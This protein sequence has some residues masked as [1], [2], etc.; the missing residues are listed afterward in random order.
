MKVERIAVGSNF[1]PEWSRD[2]GA[3]R[4]GV[5]CQFISNADETG[6]FNDAYRREIMFRDPPT[7]MSHQSLS[8]STGTRNG[9]PSRTASTRTVSTCGRSAQSRS[10][11]HNIS[12]ASRAHRRGEMP[13]VRFPVSASRRFKRAEGRR[14]PHGKPGIKR[15]A[16]SHGISDQLQAGGD[17]AA[18]RDVSAPRNCVGAVEQSN[19]ETD[20]VTPLGGADI[21]TE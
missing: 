13:S 8:P 16:A 1:I 5:L 21:R 12:I 18:I 3:K 7:A 6:C 19:V 17:R 9:P 20:A 11:L 4:E 15:A 2:H 10:N 14:G